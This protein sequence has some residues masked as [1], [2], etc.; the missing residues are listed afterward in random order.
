MGSK[1][2][3]DFCSLFSLM[4]CSNFV[5]KCLVT[6]NLSK[7]WAKRYTC[8]SYVC[9]TMFILIGQ[10]ELYCYDLR[11]TTREIYLPMA[12]RRQERGLLSSFLIPVCE[13][14]YLNKLVALPRLALVIFERS[15]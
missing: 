9:S 15:D 10:P 7:F 12:S 1:G 13:S 11:G 3:S 6:A 2:P 14:C 8:H 4:V 5:S